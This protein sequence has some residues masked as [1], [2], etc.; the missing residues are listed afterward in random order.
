MA[1]SDETRRVIGP[2]PAQGR[3]GRL[4][5]A[6]GLMTIMLNFIVGIVRAALASRFYGT[7]KALR[8]AAEAGSELLAWQGAIGT[9]EAWN[10]PLSFLSLTVFLLG[11]GV[12][13][14]GIIGT[15][16]RRGTVMGVAIPFLA[17]HLKSHN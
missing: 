9:L 14:W 15:I 4:L 17:D 7:E 10:L 11:V 2:Y 12:L 13:L 3:I 8:D 1:L 5:L 6:A 16:Q